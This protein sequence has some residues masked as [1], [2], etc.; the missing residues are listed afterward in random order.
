MSQDPTVTQPPPY[1]NTVLAPTS[2]STSAGFTALTNAAAGIDLGNNTS[3]GLGDSNFSASLQKFASNV[4][5]TNGDGSSASSPLQYVFIITDGVQDIPGSCTSGHC[6]QAFDPSICTSLKSNA[7]VGVI[8]TTYLPVY[9]QNNSAYGYE[10]NYYNL[11]YPI[12]NQIVPNLQ[13]C[14]SLSNYYI[15]AKDGPAITSAMSALF[16]S[17]SAVARLSK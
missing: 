5:G 3:G 14:V 4:L 17:T 15:E 9:N 11:V 12:S 8:Y 2:P 7:T 13:S 6:V 1:L 16:Q 10:T